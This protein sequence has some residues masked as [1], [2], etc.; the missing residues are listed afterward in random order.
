[1]GLHGRL[2][3]FRVGLS[4]G[5]DRGR[6]RWRRLILLL[7]LAVAAMM[8]TACVVDHAPR[9]V[10]AVA[11]DHG[12]T[13]SWNPPLVQPT[14]IT[15]ILAYLVTP[16]INHVPQTPTIFTS[17]ATTETV[18]GLTNGT[19]YTFTVTGIYGLGAETPSSGESNAVTP[20]GATAGAITPAP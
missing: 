7:P 20:T 19:Q 13:V 16:L 5:A 11:G 18:S 12:A 2:K 17:T 8:L 3:A 1:M 9:R 14:P 15:P 6:S 10:S 4:R